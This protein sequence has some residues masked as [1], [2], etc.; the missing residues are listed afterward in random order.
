MR[1]AVVGASLLVCVVALST[2]A[3]AVDL[4]CKDAS[5]PLSLDNVTY[6]LLPREEMAALEAPPAGAAAQE[7]HPSQDRGTTE[8]LFSIDFP[9]LLL[10]D[11]WHTLTSPA[12]WDTTDWLLFSVG[13][14]AV[15]AVTLVDKPI[16][17]QVQRNYNNSTKNTAED[18]RCFGGVC[19]FAALG[20]FYAGGVLLHDDVAKAV[21]VDG[22]AA[23]LVAS[24]IIAPTLKWAVGRARPSADLGNHYFT[25]FST[26]YASFPS[27]ETTQAFAV[28]SVVAAHY[29]ELGIKVFSFGAAS[30]VGMARIYQ[31][32]HWTSD[33]LAGALIGTAVGT[34][35]VRYNEE[36][37][38]EKKEGQ[39]LFILP[40][41][42]PRTAGVA[43]T[44]VH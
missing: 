3:L 34:T 26:K 41:L 21:T 25:P 33:A 17:T 4:G 37:R 8:P 15:G 14:L 38:K 23:S 7:E 20:L 10:S 32:A 24:G 39:G 42:A 27:G 44:L 2:G 18:I 43:I 30:L 28:A 16:Q 1:K 36:R 31:D 13:T 40:L 6:S 19:S 35:I 12:R 9:K 11:T 29:D 5:H 22:A